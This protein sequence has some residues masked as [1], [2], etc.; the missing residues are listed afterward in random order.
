MEWGG[1]RRQRD[2]LTGA[3]PQTAASNLVDMTRFSGSMVRARAHV[4]AH[5]QLG[6]AVMMPQPLRKP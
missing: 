3:I 4:A 2:T 6:W 5:L 1:W